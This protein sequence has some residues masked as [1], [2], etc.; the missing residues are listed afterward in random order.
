[1][2]ECSE[3]YHVVRT[4]QVYN[5]Y[6]INSNS[7][8]KVNLYIYPWMR[9]L[10]RTDCFCQSYVV[11]ATKELAKRIGSDLWITY[12]I[13]LPHV[14]ETPI[15]P[16]SL[17][18][19]ALDLCGWIFVARPFPSCTCDVKS[20]TLSPASRSRN[21]GQGAEKVRYGYNSNCDARDARLH[22][23]D[24]V[25]RVVSTEVELR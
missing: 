11:L 4:L 18:V 14:M 19:L 13:L 15:V 20:F 10:I 9:C 17:Q 3:E 24:C 12:I 16:S 2:H 8:S 21:P 7:F 1:M 6:Q 22:S 25:A 5:L 23:S